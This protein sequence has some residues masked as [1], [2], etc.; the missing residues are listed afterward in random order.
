M[1]HFLWVHL[2]YKYLPWFSVVGSIRA[3]RVRWGCVCGQVAKQCSRSGSG[4]SASYGMRAP[5]AMLHFFVRKITQLSSTPQYYH[6]KH[7]RLKFGICSTIFF[8]PCMIRAYTLMLAF[9]A[10]FLRRLCLAGQLSL[11]YWRGS[12]PSPIRRTPRRSSRSLGSGTLASY[13]RYNV[14]ALLMLAAFHSKNPR[15]QHP[16][17]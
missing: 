5:R 7:F 2:R 13:K 6:L 3:T 12:W 17:E 14:W 9:W 16:T 15:R 11:R 1:L 4:C 10:A 8:G